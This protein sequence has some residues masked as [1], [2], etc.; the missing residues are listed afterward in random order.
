MPLDV[1][2]GSSLR[3]FWAVG[4]GVEDD[5]VVGS[6][7]TSSSA[8][9]R[10]LDCPSKVTSAFSEAH[11]RFAAEKRARRTLSERAMEKLV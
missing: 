1:A 4:A 2:A 11:V 5:E 8:A 7:R 3:A 10:R 9:P 6:G